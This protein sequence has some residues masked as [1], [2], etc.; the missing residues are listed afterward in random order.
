MAK[1]DDNRLYSL[2]V[3]VHREEGLPNWAIE[4]KEMIRSAG[5]KYDAGLGCLLGACVGD[6][7]GATLEFMDHDPTEQEVEHALTMPGGGIWKVAPGQITDDCELGLCLARAL[8][9]SKE[10]SLEQIAQSYAAWIR[11]RPFDIGNTTILGLGA[12]ETAP[13]RARVGDEGYATVMTDAASQLCMQSK[14]NGSLMRATPLAIW[15]HRFDANALADFARQDSSLSHPNPSCWQ[16]MAC[17]VIAIGHL[18]N[19]LGDR[20][21]AF[22]AARAWAMEHAS[23]EIVNWLADAKDNVNVGYGPQIGFVRFGFTH[24]FRHLLLGTNYPDAIYETLLGN[25][26]TDTNACIVGGLLGAAQGV[27]AIP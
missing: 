20:Q 17:Y 3:T 8:A 13:G 23:V 19:H 24:A 22:T 6:A 11:S 9:D 15:G 26:D 7:A 21:G 27:D 18:F 14:S 2:F 12:F 10:F 4:S 5:N 16:A 1:P 25:G